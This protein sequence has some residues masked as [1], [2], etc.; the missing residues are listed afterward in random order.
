[1]SSNYIPE[2]DDT[3]ELSSDEITMYQEL[4]GILR[5]AIEIGRVDIATEVSLLSAY[6][7]APRQGHLEQVIRIFGY[8]KRKSNLTLYFDPNL[9][10]LDSCDFHDYDVESFRDYYREAREELP[11]RMPKPR[12]RCVVTT[13]FVDASHASNRVTR[14]SHTGFVLFVNR[15]PIIWYSK[16]QNTIESS[17]FSSEF[18]AMKI[19]VEQI[20]AL[21]YKLRMFGVPIDEPTNVLCDNESVVN[22]SSKVE[23][24]LNKKHS[25]IAYHAVRWAVAADVIKVGK[26]HTDDNIADA[27]TKRLTVDKR[28]DLFSRWT[29]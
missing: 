8:L 7:A 9:P 29:Y 13:A 28:N 10:M 24:V 18:V 17:T 22:N 15:A 2:L 20:T 26:V 4:I 14:R 23:S 5:W 12:G 11:P 19:C 21:R 3:E 6:Q 25:S 27:F 1:M 16:R